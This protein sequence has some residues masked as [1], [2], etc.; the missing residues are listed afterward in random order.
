MNARILTGWLLAASLSVVPLAG[1]ASEKVEALLQQ[2]EAVRSSNPDAFQGLLV[3]LDAMRVSATAEELEQLKYLTAF[4]EVYAGRYDAGIRQASSLEASPDQ[5][6][7]FRAGALMVNAFALSGRFTEGLRQLQLTLNQLNG[8]D[9]PSLRQH[10]LIVAA[11]IYSQIGEYKLALRYANQILAEPA[12][13]RTWCFAGQYKFE[14]LHNLGTMPVDDAA[15]TKAIEQCESQREIVVAN[16]LR[17][18]LARNLAKK[19]DR[20][21]AVLLLEKHLREIEVVRYPRLLGE[22]HS[23]IAELLLEANDLDAAEYH[24]RLA[25]GNDALAN[26][27][28]LVMAHKV[29]YEV[30]RRRHEPVAALYHYRNYAEADKAYF[31]EVKA[32]ELAYQIVQQE[33]TQKGQQIELLN[34]RNAVLELQQQVDRA[35]AENSR[36]LM[37]LTALFAAAIGY[38]AYKTKRMHLSLRQMAE[39]D[40]LTGVCNRHHFTVLAEKA[41]TQC[42]LDGEPAALLMFDL[43]HF[44]AINDSYGHTTGDWVLR[45]VADTCKQFCRRIDHLGRIGGEEF[46]ILLHGCDLHVATRLAEDCRVR[47]AGIDTHDS[48]YRLTITA[49]FGVSASSLSG[50]DLAKLLSHADLMLYRAKREGRNRVRTYAPDMPITLRPQAKVADKGNAPARAALAPDGSSPA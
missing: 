44:K 49:S 37:L 25:I 43:D 40:A 5:N 8:I 15:I 9:D 46:A 6:M 21:K 35:S 41:L 36:L 31:T 38:W 3:Q 33:N 42:A 12:P 20:A 16:F 23:L 7:R 50:Y 39:T 47:L 26:T 11:E 22:M 14:A 24:A 48:G 28:P 18:T 32:R 13:I 34:R 19:G 2:A 27:S 4:R 17:T 10:G 29:L 1:S 45:R 30:A